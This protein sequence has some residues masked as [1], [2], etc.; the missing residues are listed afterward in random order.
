MT[1][2]TAIRAPATMPIIMAVF[3]AS[4][5]LIRSR[6]LLFFSSCSRILSISFCSSQILLRFL[7]GV[8]RNR[9][10]GVAGSGNELGYIVGRWL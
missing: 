8:G 6:I 1:K 4:S 5:E 7:L 9:T 2:I 3:S 10:R